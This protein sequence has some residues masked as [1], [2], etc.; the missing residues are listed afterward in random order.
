MALLTRW[1]DA[2]RQELA[3]TA[4]GL[5]RDPRF[6]AMVVATLSL[7]IGASAALFSLADRLFFRQPVGVVKPDQLRRIYA[8]TNWTLGSVTEIRDVIGYAQFDAVRS[9]L[10]GRVELA[11]YTP[12]DTFKVGDEEGAKNARGVYASA[13]LL[14]LIGARTAIGRTFTTDEDRMENGSEVAVIGYRLWKTVFAGD[15]SI[16]GRVVSIARQRV[17]VVGVM[18]D[19]FT[20][21]DLDPV[22]VWL[23][24][25]K[26]PPD[27]K[28]VLPW[29]QEWRY[30]NIVRAVGRVSSGVS[31][32][33]IRSVATTTFRRGE[34]ANVR[35]GPDTAT[36][37]TGP[38]LAALGPSIKPKTEVAIATRLAGVVGIVLLIACANV[39]NLL[40]VRG[41]KRQRELAVRVALGVP[42]WRLIA[43]PVLDALLLSL[44][45]AV[46][47]M[48][49]ASWGSIALAR[50]ILPPTDANIPPID[51][52]VGGF[53][54][55]VAVV[56]GLLGSVGPTM[57][58]LRPDVMSS[59][60]PGGRAGNALRSRSR[61]ALLACQAALS[62]ILLV[63]AGLFIRSL[64]RARDIDLGMD[65]DHMITG[66]V[67]FYDATMRTRNTSAHTSE[68]TSG[69]RAASTELAAMPGVRGTALA[70]STPLAGW[71][72][73]PLYLDGGRVP[74]RIDDLDP[75]LIAVT[76]G[77][78]AA[79]GMTL[80]A[81]RTF[82]G[83]DVPG[84]E[85]VVVLN[86]T[87]ARVY[88]P[89]ES[90][91]GK[92]VV[93]GPKTAPCSRVVGVVRDAHYGA[94]VEKPMVGL[95][96]LVEQHTTGFESMPTILVVRTTAG[97]ETGVADA[98]RR[99]LRR[100]FPTAEPPSV[101]F[102]ADTVY[103]GLKP[104]RLGA[105]LFSMFGALALLVAAVGAYGLIAY[106]VSQRT[107]EIGVRMALGARS[108]HVVRLVMGEGMRAVGFGIVLGV[109]AS[110][111]MGRLV[112][113]MLYNTSPRDP[114]VL[115]AVAAMLA[116]VAIIASI[117]PA[118]RAANTEPAIAL[119]AE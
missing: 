32:A 78:F 1:L 4:R 16:L 94:V 35:L 30:G 29:Y 37:L 67:S 14:P 88:W 112:A 8:R 82:N 9:A 72:M 107:H 26:Y 116:I 49:I 10:S 75:A 34:I 15:P 86:E 73:V 59:M 7:G 5:R 93:V 64:N 70:S 40:L 39:A 17:T 45:A 21:I 89:G 60:K 65:T 11:A 101:S 54:I 31:D 42:K 114:I 83:E 66:E 33:W 71:A 3:Y 102:T 91:L 99:I 100:T 23:P 63:G 50:M 57:R 95:F 2:V 90:P 20:G 105:M 22:D 61:A 77:Y 28:L 48:T 13:N 115:V 69:M 44:C 84:S 6:S 24:L 52:R 103:E 92:C 38:I 118:W 104:W 19:G 53:T 111:A 47:A 51:L 55:L 81:G 108:S 58:A 109:I 43:L 85:P 97:T 113:S 119:R 98:M 36:I 87:A 74:P 80:V 79:T 12:P 106:A 96:S 76:R 25:A 46:V 41:I 110:L 18:A 62:V 56:A 27:R 68:I 117:V